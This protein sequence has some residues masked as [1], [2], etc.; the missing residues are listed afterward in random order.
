MALVFLLLTVKSNA[1]S[2]VH[3]EV[4]RFLCQAYYFVLR[5]DLERGRHG[6][7]VRTCVRFGYDEWSWWS[8]T[9]PARNVHCWC[10]KSLVDKI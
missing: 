4:F 1:V 2:E 10:F 5:Y 6:G 3:H 8:V 9:F 7:S